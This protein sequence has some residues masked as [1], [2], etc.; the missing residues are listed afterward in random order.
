MH[1]RH[2]NAFVTPAA[3]LLCAA[4][5]SAARPQ[6]WSFATQKD[7]FEGRFENVVV[8]SYG[9]LTLGRTL[10]P[11]P[12]EHPGE[13]VQGFAQTPDGAL[14]VATSP[15]AK[16][17]RIKDGKTEVVYTAP[18][19]FEDITAIASDVKG[20]L[21]IALS[22]ESA[23]LISINPGGDAT[24]ATTRFE[25]KDVDYIWAIVPAAD[26]TVYLGTGPH[27]KVYKLAGNSEPEVLLE[28]GQKNVTALAPINPTTSSPARTHTVWSSAWMRRRKNRSCCSTPESST[29]ML[30]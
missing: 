28:T 26:D 8:D 11:I 5:A 15:S 14:Y 20:N 7:F 12:A 10:T 29:L 21:L 27:G 17:F 25:N 9:Q 22:G 30:Y 16:V 4:A 1:H 18:K 3:I 2:I 24:A 13:S 19:G 23:K 6:S